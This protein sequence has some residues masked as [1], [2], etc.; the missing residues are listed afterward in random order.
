MYTEPNAC[1]SGRITYYTRR[2][3][4]EFFFC[5]GSK[6]LR[7]I[8]YTYNNVVDNNYIH[9]RIPTNFFVPWFQYRYIP[10]Q[11]LQLQWLLRR[12]SVYTS[13]RVVCCH[14]VLL[15]IATGC[16]ALF[17]FRYKNVHHVNIIMRNYSTLTVVRRGPWRFA[18]KNYIYNVFDFKIRENIELYAWKCIRNLH[19]TF[20]LAFELFKYHSV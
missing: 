4:F 8:L 7:H 14:Y 2:Y 15:F 5:F 10:R 20:Q 12:Y 1:H 16:E 13:A 17:Y 3:K 19:F 18:Y 6:T 11:D 9:N